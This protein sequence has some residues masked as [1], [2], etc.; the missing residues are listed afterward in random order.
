MTQ[1]EIEKRFGEYE[2][3]LASEPDLFIS[4]KAAADEQELSISAKLY[5]YTIVPALTGFVNWTLED[6]KKRGIK[7]LYFLARDGYQMYLIAKR[8]EE[9]RPL[10]I[11]C[12]Y[13]NVSRYSMRIPE[14]HLGLDKAVDKLCTNGID[15]TVNKILRRAAL[16]DDEA[17]EVIEELELKE[18]N[19]ILNGR[20][21][22]NLAGRLH[23]SKKLMTY[24]GEHSKTAYDNAMGYLKQEGLIE[25]EPYA[26]VDSGWI[27]TLQETMETLVKS[28][29]PA[30]EIQG[31]YFGM[32]E[33][34]DKAKRDKYHTY[35]FSDKKGLKRK[36]NFANSLFECIVSSQEGMTLRYEY[37]GTKY[38]PVKDE[39]KNPNLAQLDEN[40]KVLGYFL[41]KLDKIDISYDNILS[42][43]EEVLKK[44]MARPTELEV[45]A[46]GNGLFSD[47]IV[48]EGRKNVAAKL[49]DKEIKDQRFVSK[50][51]I[52]AGV[53]KAE[54]RESAWIEGS[55]VRNGGNV[56][57]GL[58]HARF[59]KY[60]VYI[61]KQLKAI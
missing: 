24:M 16:D 43:T 22:A 54:I 11:E 38:V 53:K 19:R 1:Q 5:L 8:L 45:E 41:K 47:D 18:C 29:A 60:F 2:T 52:M 59:Y 12:R 34:P 33:V 9:V 49:S 58:A 56:R 44:F 40:E 36:A 15:V 48:D 28:I 31:Y 25:K 30:V 55:I 27:G 13:L 37:N 21:I 57:S 42:V 3:V 6:A 51:L 46:Y 50:L 14:Y 26:L 32:Y 4:L 17:K 39:S 61:R 7:K 20:E 10:G 23:S 35:Y